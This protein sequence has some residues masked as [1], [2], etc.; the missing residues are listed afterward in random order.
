MPETQQLSPLAAQYKATWEAMLAKASDDLKARVKASQSN[1][2]LTDKE[3][4]AFTQ[5]VAEE[6]ERIHDLLAL[7]LK[8]ESPKPLDKATTLK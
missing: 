3:V 8:K 2:E 5:L 4:I 7:K 6:A 1:N